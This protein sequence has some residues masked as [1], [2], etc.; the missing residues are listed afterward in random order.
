MGNK[1]YNNYKKTKKQQIEQYPKEKVKKRKIY[2]FKP[3]VVKVTVYDGSG[4][5]NYDIKP[6]YSYI[7]KGV[8][9]GWYI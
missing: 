3:E 9:G 2:K 6:K 5:I 1:I 7:Y 4:K 8:P